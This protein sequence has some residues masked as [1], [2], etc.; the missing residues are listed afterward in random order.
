MKI[1]ELILK[2]GADPNSSDCQFKPIAA[3]ANNGHSDVV[4]CLLKFKANI[5]EISP[6]RGTA[7]I[8]ATMG[9]KEE[10]VAL[11]LANGCNVETKD[12]MF[13]TAADHAATNGFTNI[14]DMIAAEVE[15]RK[16]RDD[17]LKTLSMEKRTVDPFTIKRSLMASMATNPS[18][19]D[20]TNQNIDDKLE[21]KLAPL[22]QS[23]YSI[24]NECSK[25]KKYECP[26]NGNLKL[27]KCSACLSVFYCCKEHQ[28][29]DWFIHKK[30]C[31]MLKKMA[32]N[33]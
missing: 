31:K 29:E 5:D 23:P 4:E 30:R 14:V 13:R 22:R 33:V 24:I 1:V 19:S 21:S 27:S 10:V 12:P 3:A 15:R 16:N 18:H 11:L 20:M 26:D 28:A 7:L 9:G 2:H 32:A 6:G 8:A 17:K 25:C